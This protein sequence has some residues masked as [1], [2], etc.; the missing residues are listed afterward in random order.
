MYKQL[1]SPAQQSSRVAE[2]SF[3]HDVVSEDLKKNPKRSEQDTE[4]VSPLINKEGFLQSDSSKKVDI[5]ND[6]FQ[7]EYTREYQLHSK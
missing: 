2:K 4:G 3:L 1:Q 6:K 7:S 5:L